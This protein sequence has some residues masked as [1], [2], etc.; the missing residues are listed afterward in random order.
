LAF[1]PF[2]DP[3]MALDL[4]GRYMTKAFTEGKDVEERMAR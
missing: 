2:K 1:P 3:I 4:V